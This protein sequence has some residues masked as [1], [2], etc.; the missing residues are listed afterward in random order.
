MTLEAL[1]PWITIAISLALSILVPLFTQI[2]NNKHIR[3]M[4][5]EDRDEEKTQK[6]VKAYESF[7]INVGNAITKSRYSKDDD[8]GKA[9][10]SIYNLYLY[11]PKEWHNDL[12]R[13]S[14]DMKTFNW[15]NASIIFNKISRLIAEEYMNTGVKEKEKARK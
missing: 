11:V 14:S 5:K 4:R 13:L 9:G 15:D 7:L 2:A 8:F 3:K 6:Q 1:A 12:E 10:A